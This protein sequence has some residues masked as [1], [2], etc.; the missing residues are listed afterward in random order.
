MIQELADRVNPLSTGRASRNNN[1]LPALRDRWR[2][3]YEV[4]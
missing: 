2:L 1:A 3:V 4:R